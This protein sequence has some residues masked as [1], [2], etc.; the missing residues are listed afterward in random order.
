MVTQLHQRRHVSGSK[1]DGFE[2]GGLH[3]AFIVLQST[4][5]YQMLAE[6]GQA[7]CRNPLICREGF[8]LIEMKTP[9][10]EVTPIVNI[11]TDVD[12]C[13]VFFENVRVPSENMVGEP[14]QGW[15]IANHVLVHERGANL[16]TLLATT[17]VPV[18]AEMEET[19]VVEAALGVTDSLFTYRRR[20][21][22]GT[23]VGALLDLVYSD[24]ANPRALAYQL[25][26]LERLVSEMPHSELQS[27]RTPAQKL[28]LKA[29]TDIRLAEIDRLVYA[30]DKRKR[31]RGLEAMLQAA[32]NDLAAISAALTA[33]YFRHEEQPHNLLSR[34]KEK[35]G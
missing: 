19:L 13:Q 6:E 25:V 9:G 33:L 35:A 7:R 21:R 2:I 15:K 14:T 12:F 27:G 5:V 17:L 10:I 28:V 4:K 22:A 24:E 1:L 16:A 18:T 30:D 29:L 32:A 11:T 3:P 20:Y 26:T 34:G 8:L 31:R 23:R